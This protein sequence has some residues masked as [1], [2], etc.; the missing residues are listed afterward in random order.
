M[1]N[2]LALDNNYKHWVHDLKSRIRES[3]IKASVRVNSTML[4]LYWGIG[5]DIVARQAE[6]AWGN[7]VLQQLS[8][9]IREEFLGAKGFSVTNLKYMKMF[10]LFYEKDVDSLRQGFL[11][12]RH[13]VGDQMI[14]T[15]ISH[16]AGDQLAFPA[17]LGT[18]P[19]RHHVELISRCKTVKEALFYMREIVENGWSRAML[20]N[21]LDTALY[22]RKGRELLSNLVY[23]FRL[24]S[25]RIGL[26]PE[27]HL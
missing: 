19:W 13:Q 4:E 24:R 17:I 9:D 25:C 23:G 27:S 16:Q 14:E 5:A 3:Q 22:E 15:P 8:R 2:V 7:G 18:V 11:P 1:D 6:S 12:L 10:Y 21:F 26:S 20:L